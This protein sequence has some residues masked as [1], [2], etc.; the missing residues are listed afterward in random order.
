MNVVI[1]IGHEAKAL[2]QPVWTVLGYFE[3]TYA[4]H[5]LTDVTQI[6]GIFL[7]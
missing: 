1:F 6:F 3:R 2:P 4:T 7:G 5:F